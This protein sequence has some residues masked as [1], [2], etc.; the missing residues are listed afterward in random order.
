[1]AIGTTKW[2]TLR[3]LSTRMVEWPPPMDVVRTLQERARSRRRRVV[4][5]EPGDERVLRAAH[6]ATRERVA[7]ILLLGET[8]AIKQRARELG[9]SLDGIELVDP[10][11]D[12]HRA[13]Y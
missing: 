5:P 10:A 12:Q 6:Q 9:L 8:N 2:P 7:H 4:M 11:T 3:S 13:R 1:M